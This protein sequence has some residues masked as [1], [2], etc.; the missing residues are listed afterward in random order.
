ME[1]QARVVRLLGA[2]VVLLVILLVGAGAGLIVS[3]RAAK[4]VEARQQAAVARMAETSASARQALARFEQQLQ[5]ISGD[6]GG[7]LGRLDR[8]IQLMRIM[9]DEQMV[10]ISEMAG[11]HEAG[12]R[13]MGGPSSAQPEARAAPARKR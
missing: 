12:A 2:I 7:P 1:A 4:A 5:A 3:L 9:V 8:Q 6:P 11:L 10:M 13:A